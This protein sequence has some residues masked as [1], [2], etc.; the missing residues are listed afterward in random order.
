MDG[1]PLREVLLARIGAD[2]ASVLGTNWPVDLMADRVRI[3]LGE[4]PTELADGRVPLYVCAEC[5]GLGCGTVT[6]VIEHTADTVTWRDF[7]WQTDYDPFVDGEP[8]A[9]VRPFSFAREPYETTLLGAS[10]GRP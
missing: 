2:Y 7:G 9:D 5:G 6:A 1:E 10:N 8:F 3:L 4:A